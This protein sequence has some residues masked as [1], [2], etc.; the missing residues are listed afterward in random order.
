MANDIHPI[1][2][3]LV[4]RHE[5]EA[6]NGHRG[7]VVWLTGLSG[8]GKST[9]AA[10][11]ERRLFSD[12][13]FVVLLDGDNVRTGLCGDLGFSMEDRR[14]NIRRIA[15]TAKLFVGAGA[16]VLCSFV[17][18]T[19]GIRA[20]ASNIIGAQDFL[21]VYVNTPL[22][23]CESRDVKGLY[24]KARAGEIR[25]FTGIDS[26]YEAPEHPF[27]DLKTAELT[28]Q[29]AADQLL[30]ALHHHLRPESPRAN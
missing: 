18:P 3:R 10:A 7:G 17:S 26:P 13:K 30:A 4:Q 2:D 25:G 21:E 20:M 28:V 24:A 14:E 8:S 9:I 12:G 1:Y 22:E 29:A 23:V 5:R 16:L 19:R 6:A 11:V 27:L 15:E